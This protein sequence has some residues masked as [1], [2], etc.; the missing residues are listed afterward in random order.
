MYLYNPQ[1]HDTQDTFTIH[2]GSTLNMYG[3]STFEDTYL[4]PYLRPGCISIPWMN[5]RY[6]YLIMY[7]Q[8]STTRDRT[9]ARTGPETQRAQA[10]N[11]TQNVSR[12]Y[13]AC[14]LITLAQIHV[15]CMYPAQLY[16]ASQNSD[17]YMYLSTEDTPP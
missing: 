13:P 14:I 15:S 1:I 2:V 11:H 16:P 7:L 4:E 3:Y 12:M 10:H 6:M 5:L 17:T 9:H 8:I